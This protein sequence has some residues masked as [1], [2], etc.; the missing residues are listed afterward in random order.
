MIFQLILIN[1]YT[2]LYELISFFLINLIYF[3]KGIK[4]ITLLSNMQ[5]V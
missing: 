4:K 1:T 2:K 3:V 5:R